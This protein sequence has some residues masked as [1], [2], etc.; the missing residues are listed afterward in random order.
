MLPTHLHRRGQIPTS[1]H[2]FVRKENAARQLQPEKETFWY[3]HLLSLC[4]AMPTAILKALQHQ[5]RRHT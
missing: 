4:H 5:Y 2:P 1:T 3:Q